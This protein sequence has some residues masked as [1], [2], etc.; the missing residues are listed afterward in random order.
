MFQGRGFALFSKN[1]LVFVLLA[2]FTFAAPCGKGGGIWI[3]SG[4]QTCS[5]VINVSNLTIQS[6]ASLVL[7]DA[8][9]TVGDAGWIWAEPGASL[10]IRGSTVD[11]YYPG[12]PPADARF[13][14]M[15]DGASF[16]FSDSTLKHCGE[17]S[18]FPIQFGLFV[19]ASNAVSVKN[20]VFEYNHYPLRVS[21]ACSGPLCSLTVTGNRFAFNEQLIRLTSIPNNLNFSYN[22][23]SFGG[24]DYAVLFESVN[25][26]K[27]S[28]NFVSN[29]A[30]GFSFLSSSFNEIS[31]NDLSVEEYGIRL[32][33]YSF[34]NLVLGN[35]VDGS[36]YLMNCD[37]LQYSGG[38]VTGI[39]EFPFGM[40][41]IASLGSVADGTV[42][43]GEVYSGQG[44]VRIISNSSVTNMDFEEGTNYRFDDSR[45]EGVDFSASSKVDL[46][47]SECY[48]CTFGVT[49]EAL[50]PCYDPCGSSCWVTGGC[51]DPSGNYSQ[52]LNSYAVKLTGDKP[53]LY[54]STVESKNGTGVLVQ[55]ADGAVINE[56]RISG[57]QGLY[58]KNSGDVLVEHV[59][60]EPDKFEVN[61]ELREELS[62]GDEYAES[63]GGVGLES[64]KRVSFAAGQGGG[65]F[66]PCFAVSGCNWEYAPG[67]SVNICGCYDSESVPWACINL[68]G[69]FGSTCDSESYGQCY[70]NWGN[71]AISVTYCALGDWPPLGYNPS[72]DPGYGTCSNEQFCLIQPVGFQWDCTGGVVCGD[73]KL[74]C[75][76][77][78]WPDYD[79]CATQGY[80]D[81][82]CQA[83]GPQGYGA[84]GVSDPCGSGMSC[85]CPLPGEAYSSCVEQGFEDALCNV[86]PPFG[87]ELCS[88]STACGESA[89]CWCPAEGFEQ[90]EL[91]WCGEPGECM[92]QIGELN[93]SNWI[94]FIVV[95]GS[96][97]VRI[98]RALFAGEGV[99]IDVEGDSNWVYIEDNAFQ[100]EAL[101]YLRGDYSSFKNNSFSLALGKN[102][103]I[104]VLGNGNVLDGFTLPYSQGINVWGSG[105]KVSRVSFGESGVDYDVVV[106]GRNNEFYDLSSGT[107]AFVAPTSLLM[108][109]GYQGELFAFSSF[110][111]LTLVDNAL[112]RYLSGSTGAVSFDDASSTLDR[113]WVVTVQV[114]DADGVEVVGASASFE[115]IGYGEEKGY[116]LTDKE[117]FVEFNITEG[118][119]DFSSSQSLPAGLKVLSFESA[120]FNPY[121]F[122]ASGEGFGEASRNFN[123]LD[124]SEFVL[125]LLE[126]NFPDC[127]VTQG[128]GADAYCAAFALPGDHLCELSEAC[129][130]GLLCYCPPAAQPPAEPGVYLGIV[131]LSRNQLPGTVAF[132]VVL[133]VDGQGDCSNVEVSV[134]SPGGSQLFFP[135]LTGCDVRNGLHSYSMELSAPGVYEVLA[136]GE[137]KSDRVSFSLIAQQPV[138][139]P[140]SNVF[141]VALAGLLALYALKKKC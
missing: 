52:I 59:T 2:S 44:T 7:E 34:G 14:F 38:S 111:G 123:V 126:A 112:V 115:S 57:S 132:G 105:N 66:T 91:E 16:E 56:S 4:L 121:L 130:E 88:G 139:T 134:N 92:A 141:V 31:Y 81:G 96:N 33:D 74:C 95:D 20:S 17:L 118:L 114:R 119:F 137:G 84:C 77:V 15:V 125:D 71:P 128:F 136:N 127:E 93:V 35:V 73:N 32:L 99:L 39:V 8:T 108:P 90:E 101:V 41:N 75:N 94:P 48:N 12:V 98:T 106:R 120:L 23:A 65:G 36:V 11:V 129:G 103:G 67:A 87:T 54:Y 3:V 61:W 107:G 89:S 19:N 9:L 70:G 69:P 63:E 26:S 5:G 60:F 102:V 25:F 85:W 124:D 68:F 47:G 72:G 21:N 113:E 109:L 51:P 27:A 64:V 22:N 78:E 110:D 18:D 135:E 13:Y 131:G 49:A 82:V 50:L 117:G 6:G 55:N 62:L 104:D 28:N 58:V 42:S 53:G 37:G 24:G 80:A 30:G 43:V 138:A 46:N 97:N 76:S 79:S 40:S 133:Q 86:L 45:V 1:F 83:S 122:T 10:I 140:D 29:C 100:D 116:G